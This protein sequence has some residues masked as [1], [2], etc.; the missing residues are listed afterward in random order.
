MGKLKHINLLNKKHL[1][2]MQTTPN[3]ILQTIFSKN[4]CRNTNK[5]LCFNEKHYIK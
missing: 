3:A 2:S 5:F 4:A 1:I